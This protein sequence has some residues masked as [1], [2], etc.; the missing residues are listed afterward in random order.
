MAQ[1]E[2]PTV[3]SDP[4]RGSS[5]RTA[6]WSLGLAGLLPFVLMTA[7]LNAARQAGVVIETGVSISRF[8]QSASHV[9]VFKQVESGGEQP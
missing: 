3:R 9:R 5:I 1:E 7:L 8:T 2:E 6:A 4:P